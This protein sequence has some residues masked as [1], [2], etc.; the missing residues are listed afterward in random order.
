[1]TIDSHFKKQNL[2][3]SVN[4]SKLLCAIIHS[5]C[6]GHLEPLIELAALCITHQPTSETCLQV[7]PCASIMN[8]SSSIHEH[9]LLP[10]GI[11]VPH[12]TGQY[13]A[14]MF[15]NSVSL[16]RPSYAMHAGGI[17]RKW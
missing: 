7:R 15:A 3:V 6:L 8:K 16:Q 17:E 1:M 5:T 13:T 10:S 11:H 9:V 14:V 4:V 12:D 2:Q